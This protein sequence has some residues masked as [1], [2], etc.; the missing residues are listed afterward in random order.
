MRVAGTIHEPEKQSLIITASAINTQNLHNRRLHA[1]AHKR[2]GNC[3]F[4]RRNQFYVNWLNDS[5]A[6]SSVV[7]LTSR[8]KEQTFY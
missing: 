2:L 4:H 8:D 3:P 7:L 6:G 1:I 5:L